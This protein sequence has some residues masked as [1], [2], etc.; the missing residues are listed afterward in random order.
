MTYFVNL[1]VVQ[2]NTT[3][4]LYLYV[5]GKFY[6]LENHNESRAAKKPNSHMKKIGTLSGIGPKF[7]GEVGRTISYDAIPF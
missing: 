1:Y 4:D 7:R 5:S 6:Q 3:G 2:E